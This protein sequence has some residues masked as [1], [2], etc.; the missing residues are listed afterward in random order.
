M[1]L[2]LGFVVVFGYQCVEQ[3]GVEQCDGKVDEGYGCGLV[4]IELVESDFYKIN[5]QQCG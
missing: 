2:F 1:V 4:E 3:L 5:G